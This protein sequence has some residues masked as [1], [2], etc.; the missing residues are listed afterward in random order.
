MKISYTWLKEFFPK[1]SSLLGK[2]EELAEKLTNFGL[3][4]TSIESHGGGTVSELEITTNRGDCLSHLGIAREIA[5]IYNLPLKIP[6]VHFK[7][8]KTDRKNLPFKIKVEKKDDKP[9]FCT[10]YFAQVIQSVKI[11]PSPSWLAERLSVCGI[12]PIN[13]IVDITNYVLLESGQPLHAFDY[14]LV[15]DREIN[16]RWAKRGEKIVTLDEKE[17]I[18]DEDIPVI[19]DTE[20]AI[21]LAG[22]IGGK[23]TAVN[24]NTENILLESA[25]FNPTVIRQAAKKLGITTESSY[26]FERGVDWKN[27][28]SAGERAAYLLEQIASGK[29]QRKNIDLK[30]FSYKPKKIII[31]LKEVNNLL[32]TELKPKEIIFSLRQLNFSLEQKKN[33]LQLE[34]PSYRNDISQEVDLI[35]EV[36]RIYGYRNIPTTIGSFYPGNYLELNTL[37]AEKETRAE[38]KIRQLFLSSGLNEVINYNLISYEVLEE[39]ASSKEEV[40]FL[41]NP[42][43]QETACLRTTLLPGLLRNAV[44]NLHHQI[45]NI[46]IFEIGKIY[47]RK[48]KIFHEEKYLAGLISGEERSKDW[49]TK[50]E[51]ISFYHLKGLI[52]TSLSNLGIKNYKYQEINV[53]YFN[54]TK[55][56]ALVLNEKA[57]NIIFGSTGELSHNLLEKYEFCNNLYLFEINL[58]LLA[59]YANLEKVHTPLPKYPFIQRD[60]SFIIAENIYQENVFK[61]ILE[62]GGEYLRH[63]QL[64]DLYKD[65]N[66]PPG[67]KSLTYRLIYYNPQVTLTTEEAERSVKEII[68]SLEEQFKAQIRK[69]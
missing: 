53:P 69:I 14:E 36:A 12:R 65:E 34:I 58:E 50:P 55:S 31:D 33:M 47:F 22:I 67:Y 41:R 40:I 51:E 1:S 42:L 46:K 16:V 39:F 63:C 24:D 30:P 29:R 57:G 52:D 13:N 37:L 45:E 35:E 49:K 3:E 44:D 59:N 11:A 68:H 18:L 19:A 64:L 38:K 4:V 28:F 43:S 2:P 54:S 8:E 23:D 60:L 15:K 17:K 5:A 27:V 32:G 66:I 26:R 20:R 62:N 61:V 21:A 10:R 48:E 9:N 56:F 25:Y 6:T 7:K